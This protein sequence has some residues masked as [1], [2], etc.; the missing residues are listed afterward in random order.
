ME[1]KGVK[2]LFTKRG[3]YY[4]RGPQRSN[5]RPK[6][7]SLR[8]KDPVLA[9]QRY[10]EQMRLF[11]LGV[12]ENKDSFKKAVSAYLENQKQLVKI[13]DLE[14][15]TFYRAE[16]QLKIFEQEL[17]KAMGKKPKGKDE[18]GKP[19]FPSIKLN[20]ITKDHIEK[21]R[22]AKAKTKSKRTGRKLSKSTVDTYMNILKGLFTW[23]VDEKMISETPFAKITIKKPKRT[24]PVKFYTFEER[25]KM[26]QNPPDEDCEFILHFGFFAGLRFEEINAIEADWIQGNELEVQKTNHFKPKDK[27]LR[28]VPINNKLRDFLKRY[29]TKKKFMYKPNKTTW[30]PTP[31]NPYRYDPIRRMKKYV[32]KTC[33]IDQFSFSYHKL[34]ASFATHLAMKGTPIATIADLLGDDFSTT[35]KNYIGKM[36][37]NNST[38]CL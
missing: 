16:N 2:G 30:V 6:A 4:W 37:T 31:T 35:E 12:V 22:Q 26:L 23:C 17:S 13:G 20:K 19:T 32:E 7:K 29:G 11:Q 33:G 9:M 8:T 10:E 14:P 36:P 34:R 25:D 1:I 5:E 15:K 21:W 38:A 24:K 3:I 28:G 18:N 27:E